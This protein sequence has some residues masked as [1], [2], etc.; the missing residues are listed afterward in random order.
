[1][2]QFN[3]DDIA[4]KQ[5][6]VVDEE[7]S[8]FVKYI[9][10]MSWVW[11]AIFILFMWFMLERTYET[12]GEYEIDEVGGVIYE[13]YLIQLFSIIGSIS[14]ILSTF[15]LFYSKVWGLIPFAISQGV[16]M[17]MPLYAYFVSPI[18][19]ITSIFE[20]LL[21]TVIPIL[22]LILFGAYFLVKSP[23]KQTRITI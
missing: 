6:V 20:V 23:K 11:S 3:L 4:K 18:H 14:V 16:F 22:L 7:G 1:L 17:F 12:I 10:V 13:S 19:A 15:P 2:D 21:Y 9:A 8:L 5:Q